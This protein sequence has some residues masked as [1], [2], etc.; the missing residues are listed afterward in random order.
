MKD[1]EIPENCKE[2]HDKE[3]GKERKG[4]KVAVT[5]EKSCCEVEAGA[6][7]ERREKNITE[8]KVLDDR[9]QKGADQKNAQ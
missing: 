1:N 5:D 4:G 8:S 9:Y 7:T 6:E 3:G 2:E